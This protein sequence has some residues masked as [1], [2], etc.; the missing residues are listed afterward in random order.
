LA[1]LQATHVRNPAIVEANWT[2]ASAGALALSRRSE[3]TSRSEFGLQLDTDGL[4]GGVPANGY[5]RAAW[6]HHLQR[7]A[8]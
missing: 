8:T 4:F 7:R 2:G 6:A 3:T 1:A 5:V